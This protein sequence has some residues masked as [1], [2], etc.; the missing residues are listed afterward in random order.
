MKNRVEGEI[1]YG[2]IFIFYFLVFLGVIEFW[3]VWVKWLFFFVFKKGGRN[4]RLRKILEEKLLL[5]VFYYSS[6]RYFCLN[7][8]EKMEIFK[9]N[10][11]IVYR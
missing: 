8:K 1:I 7:M 4:I 9:R 10:F 6:D 5:L 2:G 3:N 11:L